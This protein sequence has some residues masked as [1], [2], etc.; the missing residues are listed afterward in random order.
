[1]RWVFATVVG[2]LAVVV[3]C[4]HWDAAVQPQ[5]FAEKTGFR[6][7]RI[8]D[9]SRDRWVDAAIWYPVAES[10]EVRS[11]QS[12]W[13]RTTEAL[14]APILPTA[15]PYPLIILSHGYLAAPESLSWLAEALV[16]C[17]FVVAGV[18]HHDLH[19]KRVVHID[20][21][22]RPLD[23]SLLVTFMTEE[24]S[25]ASQIDAQRIGMVGHSMGGL[26][27]LWLAGARA[28]LEEVSDLV[29]SPD[30]A[31]GDE[32]SKMGELVLGYTR[33]A[34]WKEDYTDPRIK[35]FVTM[36]P[37]FIW[38]F[39]EENLTQVRKPLLVFAGQ[40]DY[41]INSYFNARI[42]GETVPNADLWLFPPPAGHFFFLSYATDKGTQLMDPL[43]VLPFLQK[44]PWGLDRAALQ[45]LM[46]REVCQF[47]HMT[48]DKEN[49]TYDH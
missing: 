28:S 47:F 33:L 49:T 29:P 37:A 24:S 44:D 39:P 16:E 34:R 21:W 17:G 38:I 13:Y 19:E 11:P 22:N 26:T 42:L 35:A 23:V 41:V 27:A 48:L 45:R 14:N 32:F 18:Q 3:G 25:L 1:M 5:Y 43:G 31:G 46:A 2:F 10:A 12:L 30:H 15:R 6:W 40:S 36:A 7:E 20:H 8:H 9:T 4:N